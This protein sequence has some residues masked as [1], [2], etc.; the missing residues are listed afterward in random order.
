MPKIDPTRNLDTP[1]EG[2][3]RR[4]RRE[5]AEAQKVED[6]KKQWKEPAGFFQGARVKP[7]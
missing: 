1:P 5:D 2:T 7:R 3:K 6:R 4:K